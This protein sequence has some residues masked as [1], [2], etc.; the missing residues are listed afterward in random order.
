MNHTRRKMLQSLTAMAG[1]SLL[2]LSSAAELRYNHVF[3]TGNPSL[4]NAGDL[5]DLINLFDFEKKAEGVMTKMA[6]EYVA[7][8]A[9]DE[10]TLKWNREAFDKIKIQTRV[11]N[12]VN[13]IDTKVSIFGQELAYPILI[14][15]SSH[16][17]IMHG[18]EERTQAQGGGQ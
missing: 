5:D 17:K 7:S 10:I 12:N 2:P 13:K 3:K 18:D 6:Y 1:A 4:N 9:A 8:G 16:H 14:A 15:P 11:L